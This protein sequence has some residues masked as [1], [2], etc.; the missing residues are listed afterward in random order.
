[1]SRYSRAYEYVHADANDATYFLIHQ[2]A[3]LQRAA[4]QLQSY[5]ARQSRRAASAAL[6]L[7]QRRDL[8]HRQEVIL[9]RALRGSQAEFTVVGHRTE[10]RVANGTAR[11][12][13][14]GLVDKGLFVRHGN[15]RQYFFRP[16]PNL[17]DRLA[18]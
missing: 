5:I 12:D 10:F 16:A 17:Q 15:H 14:M 2:I 13:L 18:E 8:N 11:S 1:P 3:I 7:Q 4:D 9:D 6:L